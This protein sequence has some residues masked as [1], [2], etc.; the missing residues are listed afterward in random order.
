MVTVPHIAYIAVDVGEAQEELKLHRKDLDSMMEHLD[1][2][3]NECMADFLDDD[4]SAVAEY[5]ARIAHVSITEQTQVGHLRII[6][7][8][9]TFH[10]H[11]NLK[12]DAMAVTSQTP[13]DICL[14]IT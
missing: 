3:M 11:R 6:K 4:N 12:W 10:L 5:A 7:A 2:L 14:F 1:I 9:L 8:Y 13:D